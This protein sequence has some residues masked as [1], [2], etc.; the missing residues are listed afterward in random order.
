MLRRSTQVCLILL[1]LALVSRWTLQLSGQEMIPPPQ[2][3]SERETKLEFELRRLRDLEA[4]MGQNHPHLKVTR[5]RIGKV[6]AELLAISRGPGPIAEVMAAER[7]EAEKLLRQM[8]DLEV[9][10]ALLHLFGEVKDLQRRIDILE[11]RIK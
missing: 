2:S 7:A 3:L 6:Q 10:Q 4:G 11:R 1:G 5:E 8:S 9:R